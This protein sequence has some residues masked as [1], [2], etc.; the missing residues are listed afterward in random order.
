[1]LWLWDSELNLESWGKIW[2]TDPFLQGQKRV[3]KMP[4]TNLKHQAEFARRLTSA[5][6]WRCLSP[7]MM[8]ICPSISLVSPSRW[9]AGLGRDPRV[10][11]KHALFRE[12]G[13]FESS[14]VWRPSGGCFWTSNLGEITFLRPC[15][16]P[17]WISWYLLYVHKNNEWPSQAQL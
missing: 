10:L 1:M 3:R 15:F 4:Q 11:E 2:N 17:G 14:A 12:R 6:K 5:W 9:T 16:Q 7:S 13:A 8:S